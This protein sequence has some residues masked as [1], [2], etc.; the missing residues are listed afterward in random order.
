MWKV[1]V[2]NAALLFA[3]GD[4]KKQPLDAAV[5][6]ASIDAPVDAACRWTTDCGGTSFCCW[7][8]SPGGACVFAGCVNAMTAFTFCDH[9]LCDP[10]ATEPCLKVNGTPG[11]CIQVQLSIFDTHLVWACH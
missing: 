1:V 8:C 2:A 4:S 5:P 3:C 11:T 10:A 9:V 7:G 6:D